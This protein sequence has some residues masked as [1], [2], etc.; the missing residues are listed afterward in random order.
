MTDTINTPTELGDAMRTAMSGFTQTE[1]AQLRTS[2]A[3]TSKGLFE[4]LSSLDAA[5]CDLEKRCEPIIAHLP[6]ADDVEKDPSN[7]RPARSSVRGDLEDAITAIRGYAWR[8]DSLE[9]A[10]EL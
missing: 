3:A 4:A 8:I 5:L 10:V 6:R 7:V 1:A 2:I 9:S